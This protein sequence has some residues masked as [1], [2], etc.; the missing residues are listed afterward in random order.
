VPVNV[1]KKSGLKNQFQTAPFTS[2]EFLGK[3][4]L[5]SASIGRLGCEAEIFGAAADFQTIL[6]NK[7]GE[8]VLDCYP[9]FCRP[10]DGIRSPAGRAPYYPT[11]SVTEIF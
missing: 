3:G 11:K 9:F 4:Q 1:Q 7:K 5:M 10:V 8:P 2:G 6:R